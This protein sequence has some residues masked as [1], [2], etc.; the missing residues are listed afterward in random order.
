MLQFW[1]TKERSEDFFMLIKN[2]LIHDAVNAAPYEADILTHGGK[3]VAIGKGLDKGVGEQ[4]YDAAGKNIYPGLVEAHCHIGLDNYGTGP[5]GH[6]FNERNDTASPQLR[7]IDSFNPFDKSIRNALAG[8]VTTVCTGPGSA[9]VLGGTFI[10]VKM[11]GV[12]VDDMVVKSPVAMK[13]AFGENPK[14]VYSDK[15]VSARMTIAAKLREALLKAREYMEKKEN[16]D[17][18]SFDM[19]SEALIPVLKGEIPLKA[20]AHRA[21]DICTAIRIAKEFDIKLTLEHCTEGHLIA[22]IIARSGYPVAVG[23][24]N[25]SASKVELANKDYETAGI[26]QRAGV[27]VSIITD[28]PVICQENLP[29]C[30]GLAV[31]AGMD[32]FE[33]LK[34]ITINPARHIG[35]AD[36]VGSLEAG[37]DADIVITD[38]DILSSSTKVLAVFLNGERAV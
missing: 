16:G 31:K 8:G 1:R 26:L 23:P 15:G 24:T 28:S 6:D 37:K 5:V 20:H 10:A 17:K 21:D 13:C 30:A 32:P 14:R 25:S 38:G 4:V 29:I 36:R 3:I 18:P 2:G 19:K 34:A 27:S 35:I 9:N 7:G 22:D 12:C 33:A 11:R